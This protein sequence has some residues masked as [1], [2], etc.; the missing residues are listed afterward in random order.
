[1]RFGQVVADLF[2][3]I[4]G[5]SLQHLPFDANL[6]IQVVHQATLLGKPFSDDGHSWIRIATLN[7][8]T[9]RIAHVTHMVTVNA[10][11][12]FVV[13]VYTS[14]EFSAGVYSLSEAD[15]AEQLVFSVL[16]IVY[17]NVIWLLSKQ[18]GQMS[19][20]EVPF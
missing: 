5:A 18:S 1:M 17:L 6:D 12:Y 16:E 7:Q 2:E 8:P 11:F 3:S 10:V 20:V 14:S 13:D 19:F 15:Q 9:T 4:L